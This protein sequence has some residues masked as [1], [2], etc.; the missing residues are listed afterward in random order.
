M[1]NVSI[2]ALNVVINLYLN[3]IGHFGCSNWEIKISDDF[4]V[5]PISENHVFCEICFVRDNGKNFNDNN[6][7]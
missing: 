5:H 4:T 6:N 1:K 2:I 7:M 3:I